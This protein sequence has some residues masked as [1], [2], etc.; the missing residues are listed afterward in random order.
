VEPI[1]R[2][3][4]SL[5]KPDDAVAPVKPQEIVRPF[6]IPD[7]QI[8]LGTPFTASGWKVRFAQGIRSWDSRLLKLR[9]YGEGLNFVDARRLHCVLRR[10]ALVRVEATNPL[11]AAAL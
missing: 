6:E 10:K 11:N 2:T 7:T 1:Q 5:D 4:F 9:H 8:L 3:L